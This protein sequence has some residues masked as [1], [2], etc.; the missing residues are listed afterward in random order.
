MDILHINSYSIASGL[1]KNLY[2][3]L[4]NKGIKQKVYIPIKNKTDRRKNVINLKNGTFYYVNTFNNIDR[5]LYFTKIS[6][7]YKGL[8][9]N[10]EIKD[11]DVAHA[12][13]LF[14]NGGIANELYKDYKVKYITAVRNTDL[15]L[16]FKY[17]LH[18]RKKGIEIL[19]N[20]Y[21]IIFISPAHRKR[22]LNNYI[23]ENIKE[24]IKEKAIVVPNGINDYWLKNRKSKFKSLD[25]NINLLYAGRIDKNKNV[26]TICKVTSELNKKGI[27]TSLKIIGKGPEKK[28]IIKYANKFS[29]INVLGYMSKEKLLN[30]YRESDIFIMPSY[31]ETFG[32]VYVEAMSQGLPIVYTKNEGVDG[33]FK[34]GEV[35]YAV[36]PDNIEG[37]VNK[38]KFIINDYDNISRRALSLSKKFSWDRVSD[39]YIELYSTLQ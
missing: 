2:R 18:L 27:E 3:K 21:K 29:Y 14:V 31:N 35:G 5:V 15:N 20:A 23:P 4:D 34:K 22:L 17:F 32:L 38:V 39:I 7:S 13:S 16:F 24:E 36:S 9:N 37:I 1:Y 11:I 26:M 28:R 6:K 25:G 10:V 12:H 19:K 8:L 33:Y 30:N